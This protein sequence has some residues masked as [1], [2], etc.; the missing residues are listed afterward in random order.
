MMEETL[1]QAFKRFY[2]DYRAVL[3][4]D[5]SFDGSL[6]VL[7]YYVIDQTEIMAQEGNVD[8]IRNLIREFNEI[9]VSTYGSNDSV[10]ERFEQEYTINEQHQFN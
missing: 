8:K 7:P 1:I 4:V 3:G 10:K 2:A 6:Q 5:E 9:R